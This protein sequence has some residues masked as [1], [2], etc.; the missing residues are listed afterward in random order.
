MENNRKLMARWKGKTTNGD[1][2]HYYV[3]P[4]VDKNGQPSIEFV[5]AILTK[6]PEYYVH[7]EVVRLFKGEAVFVCIEYHK[8]DTA[9]HLGE[10]TSALVKKGAWK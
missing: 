2:A 6:N 8:V 10:I 5:T 4:M 1:I 7:G 3:V 9:I